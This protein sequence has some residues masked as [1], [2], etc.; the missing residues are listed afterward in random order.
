MSHPNTR[1]MSH[2]HPNPQYLM[3]GT[4][5]GRAIRAALQEH[6]AGHVTPLDLTST[7]DR[8]RAFFEPRDPVTNIGE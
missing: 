4:Q 7:E 1:R 2:Q 6:Q 5:E 3:R 8:I